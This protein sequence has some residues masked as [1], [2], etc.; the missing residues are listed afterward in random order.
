MASHDTSPQ[1][2]TEYL[3]ER[4]GKPESEFEPP[5]DLEYPHP[6]AMEWQEIDD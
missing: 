2:V 6:E 3:S 5:E 1:S 4:T